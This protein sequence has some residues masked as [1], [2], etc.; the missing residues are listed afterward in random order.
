MD[1]SVDSDGRAVLEP[2]AGDVTLVAISARGS[3]QPRDSASLHPA[4]VS[5]MNHLTSV[6][7]SLLNARGFQSA[8]SQPG[9]GSPGTPL[10]L[11]SGSGINRSLHHCGLGSFVAVLLWF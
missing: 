2:A 11:S 7:A 9:A 4:T 10:D 3:K 1:P 8:G 6:P 5:K